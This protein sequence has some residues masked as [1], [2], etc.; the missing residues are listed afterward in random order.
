MTE[1]NELTP[2]ERKLAEEWLAMCAM[3]AC[4]ICDICRAYLAATALPGEPDALTGCADDQKYSRA[5][6]DA[7]REVLNPIALPP[8]MEGKPKVCHCGEDGYDHCVDMRDKIRTLQGQKQ[9][10]DQRADARYTQLMAIQ[11]AISEGEYDGG[12]PAEYIEAVAKLRA[13]RRERQ[14]HRPPKP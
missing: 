4:G 8:E 1:P 14:N 6:V 5:E 9:Q 10:S 13:R 7:M 2:R 3:P 11:N 12:S